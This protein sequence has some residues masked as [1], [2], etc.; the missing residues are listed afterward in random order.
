MTNPPNGNPYSYLSA[1]SEEVVH[2]HVGVLGLVE[3]VDLEQ[4]L[5]LQAVSLAALQEQLNVLTLKLQYF[6]DIFSFQKYVKSLIHLLEWSLH[7]VDLLDRSW[8]EGVDQLAQG[9]TVLQS[10]GKV[11]L[12]KRIR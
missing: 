6:I 7:G 5:G 9:G 1:E 4:V 8:L 3:V 12:T 10:V 11:G 2:D